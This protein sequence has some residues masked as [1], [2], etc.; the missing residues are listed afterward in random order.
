MHFRECEKKRR[1]MK[2]KRTYISDKPSKIVA[3]YPSSDGEQRNEIVLDL[4]R[5]ILKR[6]GRPISHGN[7]SVDKIS[8]RG[9]FP[10][11]AVASDRV[12]SSRS[13]LVRIFKDPIVM[14]CHCG[15]LLAGAGSRRDLSFIGKG[16]VG[17]MLCNCKSEVRRVG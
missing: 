1:R 4:P 17:K 7:G 16:P 15:N 11:A 9:P 2:G 6:R 5:N 13:L 8:V 3:I 12:V 10:R 14:G